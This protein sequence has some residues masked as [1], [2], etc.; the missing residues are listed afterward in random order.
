MLTH[1]NTDSSVTFYLVRYNRIDPKWDEPLTTGNE[2][3]TYKNNNVIILK[4]MAAGG[5]FRI[6]VKIKTTDGSSAYSVPTIASTPMIKTEL[7]QF[8]D[9]INLPVFE[10]RMA[11]NQTIKIHIS[12]TF[13]KYFL[14]EYL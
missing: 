11:G 14:V 3:I 2:K 4:D 8:H 10:N 13:N 12:I 9:S 6:E 1:Q 5:T 7:G